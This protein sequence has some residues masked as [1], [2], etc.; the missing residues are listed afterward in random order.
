M[1]LHSCLSPGSDDVLWVWW[2]NRQGAIQTE[3]INFVQDFPRFL[4]LLFAFQRFEYG[5]WG[6]NTVLDPWS[7]AIHCPRK[8]VRGYR[9]VPTQYLSFASLAS[10]S[11]RITIDTSQQVIRAYGLARRGTSVFRSTAALVAFEISETVTFCGPMDATTASKLSEERR[12]VTVKIYWQDESRL[13]EAEGLE[14]DTLGHPRNCISRT[15]F[16]DIRQGSYGKSLGSNHLRVG[17]LLVSFGWPC[18]PNETYHRSVRRR[19]LESVACLC[20]RCV[21][22]WFGLVRC[23]RLLTRRVQATM[24]FGS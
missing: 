22:L 9:M 18:F 7:K 6:F 1:L 15:T 23:R 10:E 12:E 17:V 13:N 8:D 2:Y 11:A 3:G 4:I 5:D 20:S 19:V 14:T 16:L 21:L 24:H